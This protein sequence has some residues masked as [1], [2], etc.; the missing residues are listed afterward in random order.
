MN[1]WEKRKIITAANKRNENKQ[2]ILKKNTSKPWDIV[3]KITKN[4]WKKEY[5]YKNEC[6]HDLLTIS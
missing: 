1:E 6:V 2:K 3:K 5:I 4:N